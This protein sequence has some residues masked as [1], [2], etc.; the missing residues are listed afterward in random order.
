MRTPLAKYTIPRHSHENG[1]HRRFKLIKT[2]KN[3]S[4]LLFLLRISSVHCLSIQHRF[5]ISEVLLCTYLLVYSADTYTPCLPCNFKLI[6]L[7]L[8]TLPKPKASLN[9]SHISKG[10]ILKILTNCVNLFSG[11]LVAFI[12]I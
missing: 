6:T 10:N 3:I 12:F 4:E 8:E 7:S 2:Q 1:V 5:Q 11:F 9:I